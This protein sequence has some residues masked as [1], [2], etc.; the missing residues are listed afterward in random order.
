M[1][2]QNPETSGQHPAPE[3]E[4]VKGHSRGHGKAE[5]EGRLRELEEAHDKLKQDYE[6]LLQEASRNKADFVNYRNRVERD[7]SRDRKL[8]A[9]GAVELLLPVLDNLGRTLQALEGADASLLK[10]ISMVERQFVGALESLGLARIDAAGAFDPNLH[11]AVGVEPTSDPDR[12]GTIVQE[13][14]GGYL[15]GGKVIR[16]A[17]VRVARHEGGA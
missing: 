5:L 11:E 6:D 13:L 10:G 16:P 14:Q 1:K 17:R 12:D 9:E 2:G 7:R 8:A 15:L 4:P 3:Q